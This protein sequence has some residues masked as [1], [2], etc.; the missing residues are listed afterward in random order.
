V[1]VLV[2]RARSRA[3]TATPKTVLTSH[4]RFTLLRL[5]Q[6]FDQIVKSCVSASVHFI[7]LYRANGVL[8]NKH[9]V[10][11]RAE[12][13][14]LGFGQHFKGVCDYSYREPAALLQFY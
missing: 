6:D 4:S 13:L 8:D 9:R 10:V 2:V 11:R 1:T 12:R 14:F 3:R 7:G 5:D